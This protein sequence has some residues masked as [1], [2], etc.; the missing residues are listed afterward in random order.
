MIFLLVLIKKNAPRIFEIRRAISN[1]SQGTNSIAAYYTQLKA[2]RDELGSYCTLPACVSRVIPNFN[3]IYTT[4][5]LMDFLQGLNDSFSSVR[6]KF[7]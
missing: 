3:D 6:V 5:H 4:E 1:L 7:S 2:Y